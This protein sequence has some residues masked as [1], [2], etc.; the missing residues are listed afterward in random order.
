MPGLANFPIPFAALLLL[1][2]LL[3]APSKLLSQQKDPQQ[4]LRNCLNGYVPCDNSLLDSAQ[5]AQVREA[6]HKRNV[7][8]C[9][10]G[11]VPCNHSDLNPSEL[12]SVQEAEHARNVFSCKYGYVPC[13]HSDLNSSEL[14]EVQKA[15]HARN[16]FHCTYGYV[17]CN[18]ADLNSS[19]FQAVKVAE[20]ARNVFNCKHGY[21]PCNH[22]ELTAS[23]LQ[24]VRIAEYQRNV[25]NCKAGYSP[26]DLTLLQSSP[27]EV[28]QPS[29]PS[30]HSQADSAGRITFT[31]E[32]AAPPVVPQVAQQS[33]PTPSTPTTAPPTEGTPA[34]TPSAKKDNR[35]PI[36]DAINGTASSPVPAVTKPVGTTQSAP[37][38]VPQASSDSSGTVVTVI[39]LLIAAYFLIFRLLV[40]WL[41]SVMERGR[42]RVASRNASPPSTPTESSTRDGISWNQVHEEVGGGGRW[43]VPPL[44][45]AEDNSNGSGNLCPVDARPLEPGQSICR[46]NICKTGYHRD[47]WNFL[48]QENHSA[49]VSCRQASG[50]TVVVVPGGPVPFSDG[51]VVVCPQ[52]GA[53]NR[54]NNWLPRIGFRCG[55]CRQRLFPGFSDSFA[56]DIIGLDRVR[57]RVGQIVVFRGKVL[58]MKKVRGGAYL[59]KFEK[60]Y[61][62]NAF[63]LY[64][65]DRYV[66]IFRSQ[67]IRIEN[68]LGS[69]VDV[70]GLIQRHPRWNYEIVVTE[71]NAI[72]AV[73]TS[74]RH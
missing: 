15:E 70:R 33:V 44:Q 69:T 26:C 54:V 9:M 66:P 38:P 4:N 22:S 1:S 55:R 3:L 59:L 50:V 43:S 19:E 12:Q 35:D 21:V 74:E 20:Q 62:G 24:E 40:P 52:C 17:P 14:Q 5:L 13:N 31:N 60:G 57:D 72:R 37:Q 28:S 68:Y 42:Q 18:Y 58:E 23:E 56:T 29:I 39:F 8:N 73:T 30:V 7:F 65:P 61:T 63:K 25:Q 34:Q 32:D 47:C 6:A 49:C 48:Q 46:C 71:P 27:P 53:Q 11:Y 10:H 45:H 36:L 2:S 16:V 67:G 41:R 64:I 51:E